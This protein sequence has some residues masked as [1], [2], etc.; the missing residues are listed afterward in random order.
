M[1]VNQYN[2]PAEMPAMSTYAPV[3][4]QTL[5]QLGRVQQDV[6]DK[7]YEN[8][9]SNIKNW[10]EFQ[11]LSDVDMQNFY[12]LTM[13]SNGIGRMIEE[14]S[15]NPE[16]MKDAQWRAGLQGAINSLDYQKLA[17]LRRGA[18]SL[19]MRQAAIQDLVAKGLYKPSWD[20][21]QDKSG[22]LQQYD[23]TNWDTLNQGVLDQLSPIAYKSIRDMID[24]YVKGLK[25]RFYQGAVDPISGKKLPFTKGYMAITQQDIDEILDPRA[26]NELINTPEGSMWYRDIANQVRQ[27][28]PNAT[29]EDIYQAFRQNLYNDARYKLTSKPMEDEYAIEMAKLTQEYKYK[30]G[31]ASMNGGASLNF[32]DYARRQHN[33]F[34]HQVVNYAK[35]STADPDKKANAKFSETQTNASAAIQKLMSTCYE[36][37]EF[38]KIFDQIV[39]TAMQ[40]GSTP[41]DAQI[42]AARYA[43]NNSKTIDPQLAAEF[44]KQL[45]LG[46]QSQ[47]EEKD[48]A[49]SA[50][51]R[52]AMNDAFGSNPGSNPFNQVQ[53]E[54]DG[55]DYMYGDAKMRQAFAAGV[56]AITTKT[57]GQTASEF[58][59]QLFNKDKQESGIGYKINPKSLLSPRQF[60]GTFNQ[61]RT[62]SQEAA[63]AQGAKA[64]GYFGILDTQTLLDR[65]TWGDDD[66]SIEERLAKGDFGDVCVKGVTGYM[67]HSG[68]RLFKVDVAVPIKSIDDAYNF[69]LGRWGVTSTLTDL[70]YTITSGDKA[71]EDTRWE[72]G[73]ITV[74]MVLPESNNTFDTTIG[75]KRYSNNIGDTASMK[76]ARSGANDAQ[77]VALFGWK[78]GDQFTN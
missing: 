30:A 55:D 25:E 5:I 31:L 18:K 34:M 32:N 17:T 74:E 54:L 78:P 39:K 58:E 50:F 21:Y 10:A 57:A 69:A 37:A 68:E 44:N 11:S 65:G 7:A 70:G 77:V 75:N 4:F 64:D 22:Q 71:H 12:D 42:E 40:Q 1:L 14:A 67:D 19:D 26:V 24:P 20:V 33:E 36:N 35:Y 38:K 3:D 76:E 49:I 48:Y 13:G 47:A 63:E 43:F 62:W 56:E 15:L 29:E 60:L 27:V 53:I 52:D 59:N 28:N 61:L 8:L 9:N 73:Y 6:L 2:K 66:F 46:L 23:A 45:N 16:L 41:E 51:V 72:D